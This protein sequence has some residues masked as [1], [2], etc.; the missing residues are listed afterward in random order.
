M[1]MQTIFV[2]IRKQENRLRNQIMPLLKCNIVWKSTELNQE[3]RPTLFSIL[4]AC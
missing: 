4:P 1:D 3:I 2:D